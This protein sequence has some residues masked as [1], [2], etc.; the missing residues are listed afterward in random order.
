MF[1]DE[2]KKENDSLHPS[3]EA[4]ERTLELMMSPPK[5]RRRDLPRRI[6]L[7]AAACFVVCCTVFGAYNSG[8]F[9][10]DI[11]GSTVTP[12]NLAVKLPNGA[13]AESYGEIYWRGREANVCRWCA[14]QSA[15]PGAD[16][17]CG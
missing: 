9:G 8:A 10:N 15:L 12:G 7:V 1:K 2:Y 17:G 11:S 4:V 6:A 3:A 13:T 14:W 5:K 16:A